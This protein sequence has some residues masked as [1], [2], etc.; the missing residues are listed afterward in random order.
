MTSGGAEDIKKKFLKTK[1]FPKD[2]DL[3]SKLKKKQKTPPTQ[4]NKFQL[5]QLQN[6]IWIQLCN[7]RH[8]QCKVHRIIQA[9]VRKI[10]ALTRFRS[11]ARTFRISNSRFV[12]EQKI[13]TLTRFRSLANVS[14]LK[15]TFRPRTKTVFNP[16]STM[17]QT[18][19]LTV[20]I[21]IDTDLPHGP[22]I[23][24]EGVIYS[25]HCPET[26]AYNEAGRLIVAHADKESGEN[27]NAMSSQHGMASVKY[28]MK[29][30][31]KDIILKGGPVQYDAT[32]S[33]GTHTFNL[34]VQTDVSVN[35]GPPCCIIV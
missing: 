19:P 30:A 27:M 22:Y 24:R 17:M 12:L 11:R 1:R 16:K 32:V 21:V 6:K 35:A 14:D 18:N 34:L 13:F 28:E 7:K 4:K 26:T 29:H 8:R 31:L 20:N 3:K 9:V 23:Q 2:S 15:L 33:S 10:F 5:L 25:L